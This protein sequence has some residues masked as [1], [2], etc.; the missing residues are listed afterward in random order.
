M[1]MFSKVQMVEM[2]KRE[3]PPEGINTSERNKIFQKPSNHKRILS[4]NTQ[5]T[6]ASPVK[7]VP[8][9]SCLI[10]WGDAKIDQIKANLKK[11]Q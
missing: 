3:L 4:V 10:K 11:K 1:S 6:P 5:E 9:I 7:V 8:T 2:L